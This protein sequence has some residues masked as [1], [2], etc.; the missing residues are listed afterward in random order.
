[1][2]MVPAIVWIVLLENT[3]TRL[4]KDLARMFRMDPVVRTGLVLTLPV[5][6]WHQSLV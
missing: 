1:M 4:D 3:K 5:V 2:Q 6:L